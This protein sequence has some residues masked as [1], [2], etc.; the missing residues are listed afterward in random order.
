MG[1]LSSSQHCQTLFIHFRTRQSRCSKPTMTITLFED[2]ILLARYFIIFYKLNALTE[3]ADHLIAFPLNSICCRLSSYK[4]RD[5]SFGS[6]ARQHSS[7]QWFHMQTNRFRLSNNRNVCK[8]IYGHECISTSR[9]AQRR[10][11]TLWYSQYKA[12]RRMVFGCDSLHYVSETESFS[13]EGLNRQF[14]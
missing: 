12:N 14:Y 6:K 11:A 13:T 7:G 1:V 4:L 9:D 8:Q 2:R 5:Q 10:K 3:R